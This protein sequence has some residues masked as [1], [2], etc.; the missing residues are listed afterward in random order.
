MHR[1]LGNLVLALSVIPLLTAASP[2]C[3]DLSPASAKDRMA[4][5]AKEIRFHN[6]LYYKAL[7]PG[8]SDAQYDRLVAELARLEQC[9]PALAAADSPTGSRG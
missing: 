7:R 1:Y 4:H 6:D 5:L 3:S 8:I 9:F 2:N